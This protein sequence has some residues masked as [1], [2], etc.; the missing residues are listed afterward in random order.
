VLADTHGTET[1]TRPLGAGHQT[2]CLVFA[3]TGGRLAGGTSRGAVFTV[4]SPGR[5]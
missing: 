3:P 2:T 1:E 5:R 4:T